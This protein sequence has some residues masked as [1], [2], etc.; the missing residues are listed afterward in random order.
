MLRTCF[1]MAIVAIILAVRSSEAANCTLA[2][3][4]QDLSAIQ[5]AA[6]NL[7]TDDYATLTKDQIVKKFLDE[8]NDTVVSFN[9]T[10][11]QNA[12]TVSFKFNILFACNETTTTTQS[13]GTSTTTEVK[14]NVDQSQVQ[15]S[16]S[17][18]L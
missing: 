8:F 1:Y 4:A 17:A 10:V 14:A 6:S 16:V 3:Y 9:Y 2:S 7:L 5:L 15:K 11:T 13:D 12:D 18:G